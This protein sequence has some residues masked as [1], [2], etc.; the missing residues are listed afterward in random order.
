MKKPISSLSNKFW[1]VLE[2]PIKSVVYDDTDVFVLRFY[3]YQLARL[4]MLIAKEFPSK[5]RVI[6][7]GPQGD[8]G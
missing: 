7:H 2:Q 5:E 1:S 8:T 6:V 3:H 4:E